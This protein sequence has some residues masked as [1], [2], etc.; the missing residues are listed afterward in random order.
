MRKSNHLYEILE[1]YGIK[2]NHLYEILATTI[3]SDPS[4]DRFIPNT[5]A[6]GVRFT[7]KN[8]ILISPYPSTKTY[9]N[10]AKY[11]MVTINFVKNVY[12]FAL[13]SLKEPD[14]SNLP[15]KFPKKYYKYLDFS[16][17][18]K[19]KNIFDQISFSKVYKIPYI[20][21]A[22]GV[23]VC[24]TVNEKKK[25]K[26]GQRGEIIISE[27]ELEIINHQ[28]YSKS[29][30]LF[31]RAENLALEMIILATRLK[32]AYEKKDRNSLSEIYYKISDYKTQLAR[33]S[34]NKSANKTLELIEEYMRKY[35]K[36]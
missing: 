32:V 2:S 12:L 27:F 16:G 14:N 8:R 29:F 11:G 33:F 34:R 24:K 10:L 21:S 26:K 4:K 20:K 6:M 15:E 25:R 18:P 35:G 23:I 7:R 36:F 5:A 28:K 30:K 9:T 3:S 13:A 31:N 17:E 19:I 22:W 1:T